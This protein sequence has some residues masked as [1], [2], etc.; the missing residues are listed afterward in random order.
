[1][2]RKNVSTAA[3]PV[4]AALIRRGVSLE[5]LGETPL[6]DL[7]GASLPTVN[8]ELVEIIGDA[9]ETAP[10]AILDAVAETSAI[11]NSHDSIIDGLVEQG[12]AQM[13]KTIDKARNVVAPAIASTVDAVVT[14]V[15]RSLTPPNDLF[16]VKIDPLAA[17]GIITG[18][19]SQYVDASTDL[20]FIPDLPTLTS[21]QLTALLETGSAD[22]NEQVLQ[23]LA[24][25]PDG[26]LDEL[27]NDL[28][29]GSLAHGDATRNGYTRLVAFSGAKPYIRRTVYSLAP[30]AVANIILNNL[31]DNPPAN[32]PVTIDFWNEQVS[33][34]QAG[35]AATFHSLQSDIA[36]HMASGRLDLPTTLR[37]GDVVPPKSFPILDRVYDKFLERDGYPELLFATTCGYDDTNIENVLRDAEALANA[38]SVECEKFRAEALSNLS[39]NAKQ[40]VYTELSKLI[41]GLDLSELGVDPDQLW[42]AI[43]KYA[44]SEPFTPET[45]YE[46][47]RYLIA[48]VIYARYQTLPLLVATDAYMEAN[49]N[50]NPR[51]AAY[52]GAKAYT[53][54]WVC[55]Q[56]AVNR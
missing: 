30:L 52:H 5:S 24:G 9:A 8:E 42:T 21:E 45:L 43:A 56:M 51:V 46:Q 7:V 35:L 12:A 48:G 13:V 37:Q 36:Q 55:E 40:I 31:Y 16:I 41:S 39:A 19:I 54:A 3:R 33:K 17:S 10:A 20:S 34:T 50:C 23:H 29:R 6:D 49:P 53:C 2:L 27:I 1:M 25:Y 22:T 44:D 26:Y 11:S 18:L 15:D 4:V 32:T 38:W 28:V 14:S 47:V